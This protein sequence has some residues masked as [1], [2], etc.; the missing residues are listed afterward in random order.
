MLLQTP[1]FVEGM[2]WGKPRYGH[3]EGEVLYHVREVLD[4][5]DKIPN[6]TI[7]EREKLRL[8]TITHDTFKFAEIKATPRDWNL[9]HGI[10]SRNFIQQFIA[11]TTI[12]DI[13][14]LHDEAYY[15]WRNTK[16]GNDYETIK[17]SLSDLLWRVNP[18]LK[19]YYLFFKCDTQ[20][21]DKTQQPLKWFEEQLRTAELFV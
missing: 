14:E 3:P 11:D 6:I 10:L 13:V 17:Y 15:C 19:L 5:V 8:I 1:E 7:A 16:N 4:N 20:T 21:G 12:L 9:H 2:Y 18:Y